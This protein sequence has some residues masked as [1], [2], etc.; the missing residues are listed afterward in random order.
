MS[1]NLFIRLHFVEVDNFSLLAVSGVETTVFFTLS[2]EIISC[3]ILTL[4]IVDFK[5][6]HGTAMLSIVDTFEWKVSTADRRGI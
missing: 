6:N 1:A 3:L 5:E 4:T 2:I